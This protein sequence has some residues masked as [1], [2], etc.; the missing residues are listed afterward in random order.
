MTETTTTQIAEIVFSV[1]RMVMEMVA[2]LFT[3]FTN[4]ASWS[5]PKFQPIACLVALRRRFDLMA[6]SSNLPRMIKLK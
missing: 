2:F 1:P 5:S 3:N 4:A 6:Y